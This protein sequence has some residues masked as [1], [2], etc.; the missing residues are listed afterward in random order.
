MQ[1]IYK[2]LAAIFLFIGLIICFENILM[3]APIMIGFSYMGT[4][5]LFFP[6]LVI[7]TVGI[8][9]GFFMGLAI[10]SGK[11]KGDLDDDGELDI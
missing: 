6:L 8:I 5:S 4:S 1:S 2:T 11:N 9:G 7:L 3:A 10:V